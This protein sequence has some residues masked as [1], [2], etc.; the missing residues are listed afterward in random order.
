M[1]ATSCNHQAEV[2]AQHVRAVDEHRAPLQLEVAAKGLGSSRQRRR[3]RDVARLSEV[4]AGEGEQQQLVLQRA[5]ADLRVVQYYCQRMSL[6]KSEQS[7]SIGD[8][9]TQ[10]ISVGLTRYLPLG[11]NLHTCRSGSCT[12]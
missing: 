4:Q 1:K 11:V 9:L 2:L 12:F 7:S 10:N 3:C 6:T 5:V 8:V